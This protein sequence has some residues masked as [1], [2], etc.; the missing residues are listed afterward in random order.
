M[1][2]SISQWA[3]PADITL[4]EIFKRAK[5][6]GFAGVEVVLDEK[7]EIG[8]DSAEK[9]I[10]KI[11]ALAD[12]LGIE[13]PSVA[14]GLFWKY[15]LTAT[16]TDVSKK[17]IVVGKKLLE[18]GSW[19]G[20]DTVLVIPGAVNVPW[21]PSFEVV[22]Y[23]TAIQNAKKGISELVPLA[24]NLKVAIGIENVWNMMLLSPIEMRDFIDGFKS[25]YVAAYFDVGN[26]ISTGFPE[27]WIRI[28]AKRIKKVH[29]KNFKRE[30]GNL[31][32]FTGLLAGDVNWN[33]VMKAFK[34]TGYDGFLT[35]ELF[36]YKYY[37]ECLPYD[38]SKDMDYILRG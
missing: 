9:E 2:K 1:K 4:Q 31:N 20:V 5:A 36:P 3:F 7:G 25:K 6:A 37:P 24:E 35:A 26:V 12:S 15:P 13:I 11:K 28:L 16:N 8:L 17:A 18:V 22:Y 23:E 32:G 14:T 19:F 30:V 29:L 34:D 38:V 27:H 10:R 33:E 21:D